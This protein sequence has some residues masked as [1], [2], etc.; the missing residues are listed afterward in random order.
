MVEWMN[1]VYMF[2]NC[3]LLIVNCAANPVGVIIIVEKEKNRENMNLVEV[4]LF[5]STD[6]LV[7]ESSVLQD[8]EENCHPELVSGSVRR[9]WKRMD[10]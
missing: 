6:N 10:E 9:V 4:R 5:R 8:V 2:S 7:C 1:D 3:S